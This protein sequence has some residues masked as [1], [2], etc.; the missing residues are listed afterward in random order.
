MSK[1]LIDSISLDHSALLADTTAGNMAV[2]HE[3]FLQQL[4]NLL[5]KK[6]NGALKQAIIL[7]SEAPLF[8]V[9]PSGDVVVSRVLNCNEENINRHAQ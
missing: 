6:A 9:L 2:I 1:S 4:N 7:E 3:S 5:S 8:R